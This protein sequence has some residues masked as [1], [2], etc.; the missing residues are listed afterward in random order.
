MPTATGVTT[1]TRE[2]TSKSCSTRTSP[3]R[4]IVERHALIHDHPRDAGR[5][6]ERASSTSATTSRAERSHHERVTHDLPGCASAQSR[7]IPRIRRPTRSSRR[8]ARSSS[9][10]PQPSH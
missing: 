9:S 2:I 7:E 8:G 4:T 5:P 6:R 3:V 10:L 1:T